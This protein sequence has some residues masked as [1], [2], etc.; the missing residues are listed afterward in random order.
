LIPR[1]LTGAQK[2]RNKARLASLPPIDRNERRVT[3]RFHPKNRERDISTIADRNQLA[4]F[5]RDARKLDKTKGWE[6]SFHA[7]LPTSNKALGVSLDDQ[8]KRKA[9]NGRVLEIGCGAAETVTALQKRNPSIKFSATGVT[10]P[11]EWLGH[12][13]YR[14]I[15]WHV[16][17]I[18]NL[19]RVLRG[20]KFDFIYSTTTICKA[21]NPVRALN[22]I[23]KVLK[24]GGTCIFNVNWIKA[25]LF[26]VALS[27]T[28]FRIN[29]E[30]RTLLKADTRIA[31]S[32]SEIY[33]AFSIT[34]E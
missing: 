9:K 12:P 17:H 29:W 6:V 13:N 21:T 33:V 26:R 10:I 16:A 18:E 30:K 15:D 25:P 3:L 11:S 32:R 27:K 31:N 34:K 4:G 28:G 23:H 20:T 24:K 22:Q 1:K 5:L 8:V 7:T 2:E 14:E 19:A